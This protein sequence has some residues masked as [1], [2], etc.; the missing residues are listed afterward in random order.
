MRLT[1]EKLVTAQ[2]SSTMGG[3]VRYFEQIAVPMSVGPFSNKVLTHEEMLLAE[4]NRLT[5]D[6]TETRT[7]GPAEEKYLSVLDLCLV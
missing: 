7:G 1:F 6:L 4:V 3:G 5:K 2:L